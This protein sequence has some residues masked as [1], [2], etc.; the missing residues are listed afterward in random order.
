MCYEIQDRSLWRCPECGEQQEF[1]N[2]EAVPLHCRTKMKFC[3]RY[4]VVDV[5][6][7]ASHG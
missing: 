6:K 5:P 2:D 3:T 1:V 7:A 4:Q